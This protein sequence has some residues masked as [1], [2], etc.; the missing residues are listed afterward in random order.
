MATMSL[1]Y[2]IIEQFLT[3]ALKARALQAAFE[4]SIIDALADQQSIV[5]SELLTGIKCDAE[6]GLF[7]LQMLASN[8][9]V[10]IDDGSVSLTE[11]FRKALPFRDLLT[12]KLKFS[13]L[14]A[15]DYFSNLPN[16]LQSEDAFMQSSKL[17]ELF[18]YGRCLEVTTANCMHASQWMQITTMLTRY[19]AA[20]CHNHYDFGQHSKM[21]D[22]GGNSGEFCV[23][24]CRRSPELTAQVFDL[25]VVCQVGQRHV[26]QSAESAQITFCAGDMLQDVFPAG[27]DLITWKS[28]LHDWPDQHLPDLLQKSFHAL[29]PGGRLLIFERQRWDFAKEATP[30]GLLPVMLFFRSYRNPDHYQ[31]A[32]TNAG[33]TDVRLQQVQLEVPFLLITATKAG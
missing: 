28:V 29:E 21:L 2:L 8:H 32:L 25:P 12:T 11:N 27:C 7:L 33:F 9:V 4:L 15:A 18:D 20:V 30:Y 10:A 1:D 14:V 23:Q 6:G 13:T 31:H 26:S 24:I 5:A 16:L 3:D 17:F 19:E 22:I